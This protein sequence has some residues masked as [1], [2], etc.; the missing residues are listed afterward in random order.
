MTFTKKQ[1]N[2][3]LRI[4]NVPLVENSACLCVKLGELFQSSLQFL[5]HQLDIALGNPEVCGSPSPAIKNSSQDHF[6]NTDFFPHSSSSK[7]CFYHFHFPTNFYR[8]SWQV[9]LISQA[10]YRFLSFKISSFYLVPIVPIL[11]FLK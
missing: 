9:S 5:R 6:P 11:L 1:Q 8:K 4:K 3:R 7:L 10:S 2:G